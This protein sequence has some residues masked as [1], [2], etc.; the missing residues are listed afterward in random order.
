MK[1]K[2]WKA[3]LAA[4]IILGMLPANVAAVWGENVNVPEK[5]A[6]LNDFEEKYSYMDVLPLTEAQLSAAEKTEIR[7]SLGLLDHKP[8][9]AA[10]IINTF[11]N[12]VF[13]VAVQDAFD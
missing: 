1:G 8:Q 5:G 11:E 6:A 7:D 10:E 13:E 3:I 4:V 9:K 12:D 2:K